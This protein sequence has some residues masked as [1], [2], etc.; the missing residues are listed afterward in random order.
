M[1]LSLEPRPSMLYIRAR[2]P[3]RRE[4]TTVEMPAVRQAELI[5]TVR[6]SDDHPT[7]EMPAVR[8]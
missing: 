5:E 6:A 7:V 4:R 2:Q 3:G 8:P 1:K